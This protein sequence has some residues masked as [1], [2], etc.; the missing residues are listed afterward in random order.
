MAK[1]KAKRLEITQVKSGIGRPPKHRATLAALG[2]RHHQQTVVQED[3]PQIRGMLAQIPHLVSVRE[4][5][6]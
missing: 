5:E 6:G 4:V 2:I 1:K 3:S